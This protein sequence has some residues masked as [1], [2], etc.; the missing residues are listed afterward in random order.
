MVMPPIEGCNPSINICRPVAF[1]F[2]PLLEVAEFSFL[3]LCSLSFPARAAT[4]VPD[5]DPPKVSF[6]LQA[7]RNALKD[8]LF[9]R[10]NRK[11][12]IF[13]T[14]KNLFRRKSKA[15]KNQTSS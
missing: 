7:D 3:D 8:E 1:T 12:I 6:P 15:F 9:D 13:K 4:P 2:L 5:T 14:R 10:A 11:R